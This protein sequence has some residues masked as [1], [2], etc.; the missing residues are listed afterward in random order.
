LSREP[1]AGITNQSE[2][3]GATASSPGSVARWLEPSIAGTRMPAMAP[4]DLPLP[5]V[6]RDS[7][8]A[9]NTMQAAI[10]TRYIAA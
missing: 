1:R 5:T 9:R 8:H 3:G 6:G 10:A 2:Q 4:C 7:R